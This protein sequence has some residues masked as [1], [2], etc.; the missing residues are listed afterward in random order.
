MGS[1]LE[2]PSDGPLTKSLESIK[3][4]DSVNRLTR[5][6]KDCKHKINCSLKRGEY[7]GA[8]AQTTRSKSDSRSRSK[9]KTAT[10]KVKSKSPHR[11]RQANYK[12]PALNSSD[13][14]SGGKSRPPMVLID[15]C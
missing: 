4:A 9:S 7:C 13:E 8:V 5:P 14:K 1:H 11:L 12:F 3:Q 2:K 15:S 6:L 10:R